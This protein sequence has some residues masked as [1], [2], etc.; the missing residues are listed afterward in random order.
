MNIKPTAAHTRPSLS[1]SPR[2]VLV[3]SFRAA[4]RGRISRSTFGKRGQRGKGE[5]SRAREVLRTRKR[6]VPRPSPLPRDARAIAPSRDSS[7]ER[8]AARSTAATRSCRGEKGRRLS[9]F[10]ALVAFV[11]VRYID[12]VKLAGEE[13][14]C[15]HKRLFPRA[16]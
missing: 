9:I 3:N 1:P 15:R 8:A 11:S 6:T 12:I 7:G 10:S 16:P 5:D 4:M 14:C 13:E 2:S